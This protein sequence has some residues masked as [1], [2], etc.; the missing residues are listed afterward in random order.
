MDGPLWIGLN[1]DLGVHGGYLFD[2]VFIHAV[3]LRPI[4]GSSKL[5]LLAL[6][7]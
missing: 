1:C 7:D 3:I 2:V 6:P 5:L 4:L